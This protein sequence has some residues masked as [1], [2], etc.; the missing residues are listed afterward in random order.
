MLEYEAA[1]ELMQSMEAQHVQN[2][3]M[4]ANKDSAKLTAT[5]NSAPWFVGGGNCDLTLEGF[6]NEFILIE[7]F[8]SLF[9]LF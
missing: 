3:R 5:A 2:L 8:T 9:K 6:I 4:A 1:A 7:L